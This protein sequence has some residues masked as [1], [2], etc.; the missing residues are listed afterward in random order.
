[1]RFSI[2]ALAAVALLTAAS[3]TSNPP[4]HLV[5]RIPIKDRAHIQE[6]VRKGFDVAGVDFEANE[7]VVITDSNGLN[8][9]RANPR[10]KPTSSRYLLETLD[11]SYKTP[12]TVEAALRKIESDHPQLASVVSI[13][14]STDG[15]EIFA[16]RITDP[17]SIPSREKAVI[18][19][20]AMHHAREVM[21]PEIA[22]DIAEQLTSNFKTDTK[23]KEW[24]R[25]NEIWIVPMLNP[26]GNTQVWN[27]DNMWRKN[28]R[29]GYG[30]DNNRNYPYQ[31]GKCKGSSGSTRDDDYRGPSPGSEPETQALMNLA[32][33]IR[34]VINISYH[35]ASEIV[36]YP[37]SCPNDTLPASEKRLVEG[38]G[39]EL[40]SKLV[41]DSGNGT[42]T[43]GTSYELLYPV[44]GGSSD[45]MYAEVKALAYTIEANSQ[46]QGFQP[47]YSRWRDSTLERNRPG[48][49]YILDRANGASI[50]A[51]ANQGE[52]L[53]VENSSGAL[54]MEKEVDPKGWA[55]FIVEPGTYRL[56]NRTSGETRSVTV[57]NSVSVVRFP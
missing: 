38:I 39:K 49:Q 6:L 37:T 11:K 22:I 43:P 4:E 25:L 16:I 2:T 17:F 13:G 44:D 53:R 32:K 48:W 5:L 20:D 19:F 50:R 46:N 29:G 8:Q 21:T 28:T 14:N 57:A 26:D 35:T 24:L 12:E 34:P 1:M 40:A 27:S 18:L 55:H 45:W 56:S 30:V 9:L 54:I 31:W 41:R 52:K 51:K 7:F 23:T 10:S 15:K 3:R 47:S 42:Y 36:I 33:Q